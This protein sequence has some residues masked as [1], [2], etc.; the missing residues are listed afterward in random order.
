MMLCINLLLYKMNALY[1]YYLTNI[2]IILP[3]IYM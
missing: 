3:L 2:A 1:Q